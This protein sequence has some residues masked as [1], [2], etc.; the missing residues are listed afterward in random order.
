M[1][2]GLLVLLFVVSLLSAHLEKT[3]FL[4]SAIC[5]ML[6][7]KAL[8]SPFHLTR[9]KC[10]LASC[11]FGFFLVFYRWQ[12]LNLHHA[13][14]LLVDC[15][16][17]VLVV[18]SSII[19]PFGT[20]VEEEEEEEEEELTAGTG[21]KAAR[22]LKTKTASDETITPEQLSKQAQE[23]SASINNEGADEEAASGS[24]LGAARILKEQTEQLSAHNHP[25]E[26]REQAEEIHAK[27]SASAEIPMKDEAEEG[28]ALVE[29][30]LGGRAGIEKYA[31]K[32]KQLSDEVERRLS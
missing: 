18:L 22:S 11:A 28:Y 3:L 29:E 25:T 26:I 2:V 10:R 23:L 15:A 12:V 1:P 4:T 30:Q 17:C 5:L 21:T 31:A 9:W 20:G 27:S 7:H 13:T 32:S 24:G 14:E 16:D 8:P 6:V 19:C